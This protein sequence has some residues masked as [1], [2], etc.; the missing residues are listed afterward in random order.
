MAKANFQGTFSNGKYEVSVGLS[1]YIWEED[2][3]T[4]VYSPVLDVT[5]YG[6]NEIEAKKSFEIT[7]SEFVSYTHNK[8][9]IFDELER[10]G[11]TVNRK[12]KRVHAPNIDELRSDNETFKDLLKKSNVRSESREVQLA[13]V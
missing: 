7:L 6:E 12:K 8:N 4:F 2:N 10:L 13:F 9:T 5:G 3:F 11:W 1:L